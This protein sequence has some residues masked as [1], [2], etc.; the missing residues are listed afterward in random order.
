[1]TV[2]SGLDRAGRAAV[3]RILEHPKF[4][5]LPLK[6][7]LDQV[8]WL[9]DGATVSITASPT[10][11]LEDTM[12]V[13]AEL[14]LRGF[15]VVPHLSARMTHDKRHLAALL[16]RME[17]LEMSRV[18]LVGGD[19]PQRGIFPDAY[20]LL[21]AMDDLGHHLTEIGVTSYPEGHAVISDDKL[22][23]ALHDKQPFA[24]YLT[25]QM[26]FDAEAIGDFVSG[27]RADGITLPVRIGIPG[28]ADR[29]KLIQIST[30]IGVGQSVRFLSKHRGLVTKFIKPGGYA[31]EDLLEGLAPLADDP[32]AAI[33]GVHIYTFNQCETTERWRQEYLATL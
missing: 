3:R 24:S 8:R 27:C 19:A 32:A 20:S 23:Q 2:P 22:R 9:P 13:A 14:R 5:V 15:Q 12:D 29:L 6:N 1:M 30:R 31:P 10:K 25:T 33:V 28:V 18:F 4:E 16:G 17:Q 26:C 11:T 21:L 7:V